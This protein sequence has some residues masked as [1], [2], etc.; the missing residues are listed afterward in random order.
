MF[1]NLHHD[2]PLSIDSSFF[3]MKNYITSS[4]ISSS[5]CPDLYTSSQKF[6][7]SSS[8]IVPLLSVSTDLNSSSVFNLAKLLFLIL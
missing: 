1:S 2:E 8:E 6:N 7:H 4:I 5:V 3:F